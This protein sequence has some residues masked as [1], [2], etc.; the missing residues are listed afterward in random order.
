MKQKNNIKYSV[1]IPVYNEEGSVNKLHK[2]I[3]SVMKEIGQP[4][5]ILFVNDASNDNTKNNTKKL[6][7]VKLITLR[8][9]SGQSKALDIGIKNSEGEVLI[10]LDGD[11]QNDPKD[12]PAL[13][14]KL[15][16]GYDTV[17]GWRHERKDSLSKRFFSRGARFLRKFLVDDGIHDS[18]CTLRVYKKECFEDLNLQGEMH[19]MIP[20]M[21]RW[22]GF[23][24]TEIKVNHRSRVHGVTKYNWTRG[25]KGLLDMIQVWFWR[26]Y[27]LRPL[28][29][30]GSLGL[31]LII[32]SLILL[33]IL[34]LLRAFYSYHLSDKIWPLV[35]VTGFLAGIQLFIFGILADI[36]IRS[37]PKDN[38]YLIKDIVTNE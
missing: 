12:I 38:S 28:H 15:S 21:I 31:F 20:A 10:T 29:L 7:P 1:I 6:S 16:Q 26:K 33:F 27:E 19:R 18:G 25:V 23:R 14:K 30:F 37:N 3:V 32:F 36:I 9:N 34:V 4:Y 17:C 5:E 22:K 8:K 24:I 35:G 2:E 11:G 13:L